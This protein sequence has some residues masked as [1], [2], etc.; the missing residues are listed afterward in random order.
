MT[1]RRLVAVLT[2]LGIATTAGQLANPPPA[3]AQ[4]Q[5]QAAPETPSRS[6]AAGLAGKRVVAADGETVGEIED[7]VVVEDMGR[8][9]LVSIGGFLG[10]GEKRVAIPLDRLAVRGDVVR[11]A[12]SQREVAALPEWRETGRLAGGERTGVSGQGAQ[13]QNQQATQGQ[14]SSQQATTGQSASQQ[15]RPRPSPAPSPTISGPTISAPPAAANGGG[16]MAAGNGVPRSAPLITA[17]R[18]FLGPH[19]IPPREFAAYGIVAFPQGAVDDTRDRHRM[20]CEAYIAS[21]PASSE[22]GIP[23]KDQMVTV[24]PVVAEEVA[25]E[26][27][28]RADCAV[29]VDRYHLVTAL[30]ALRQAAFTGMDISGDGPYLLAWAPPDTKG[31]P[32]A[33][34]LRADL[35]DVTTARQALDIFRD[36]RREI[37]QKPE[38]WRGGWSM[39]TLRLTL[40]L[41][42]D[43]YGPRLLWLFGG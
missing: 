3:A 2:V 5:Q 22:L 16:E 10:I 11:T 1:S 27:A 36:W 4:E 15:P 32:D 21:L 42:A 23:D 39:Q 40:R 19:D 25:V 13:A 9:A 20:I 30:T 29:A 31:E 41:W 26:L 24:W 34:V 37:E 35:S 7:I 38:L 6:T 33:L 43:K 12:L 14:S 17:S 18:A 28:S 8:A